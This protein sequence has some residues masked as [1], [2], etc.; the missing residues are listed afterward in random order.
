VSLDFRQRA[1]DAS[2]A[3]LRGPR[4]SEAAHAPD[5]LAARLSLCVPTTNDADA[6]RATLRRSLVI[7]MVLGIGGIAAGGIIAFWR[8]QTHAIDGPE[9][10]SWLY[11][12]LANSLSGFFFLFLGIRRER[13][14]T[15]QVVLNRLGAPLPGPAVYVDLNQP[16][17]LEKVKLVAHDVAMLFAHPQVRCVQIEGITARYVIYGQDVVRLEKVHTGKSVAVILAY[18][19]GEAM[20]ELALKDSGVWAETQGQLIKRSPLLGLLRET[21]GVTR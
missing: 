10:D 5:I 8:K 3:A 21:L 14:F 1:F 19:I 13:Q 7:Y 20:L 18:Q 17:D 2:R 11:V 9:F 6:I 12:A 4:G 15:R 16:A